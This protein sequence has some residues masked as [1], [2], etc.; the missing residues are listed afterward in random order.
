MGR[1]KL[2]TESLRTD[3]CAS[4]LRLLDGGGPAAVT[5]RAVAAGASSSIAAVDELFG[6]KPGLVRAIHAEGFRMLAAAFAALPPPKD[7]AQGVLDWAYA[8]R[9]FAL[10]HRHLYE[11]MF[12]RPFAE[13]DPDEE[14]LRAAEEI[15]RF[16][17]GRVVA[18]VGPVRR[19]GAGRDAAIGLLALV[20]GLVAMESAGVLGSTP[21]SRDRRWRAA[22]TA[23]I[24]GIAP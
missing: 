16:V 24:R 23:A 21:A 18:V 19:R 7:P 4:A 12:S 22:L 17:L 10:A 9:S 2:R 14:D 3:L 15:Y 6:G 13:F 5:T 1:P 8:T 20:R 11:V